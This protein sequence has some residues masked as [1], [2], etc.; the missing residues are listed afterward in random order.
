LKIRQAVVFIGFVSFSL[1]GFASSGGMFNE[2]TPEQSYQ[3]AQS[4][5][6]P[7]T[8]SSDVSEMAKVKSIIKRSKEEVGSHRNAMLKKQSLT[9]SQSPKPHVAKALKSQLSLLSQA[10]LLY[11]QQ[12]NQKIES[13]TEE[14]QALRAKMNKLT[15]AL[16]LINQQF[17]QLKPKSQVTGSMS[18]ATPKVDRKEGFSSDWLQNFRS[19]FYGVTEYLAFSIMALLLILMVILLKRNKPQVSAPT[20]EAVAVNQDDDVDTRDEYDFMSSRE[21]IPA[22]LDLAR[23]YVEMGDKDAAQSVLQEVLRD[24]DADQQDAAVN[25]LN[26]IRF[27]T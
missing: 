26:E 16:L 11:Q 8:A 18:F 15:E 27:K 10:E 2:A 17:S 1:L 12:T 25:L 5:E 21:A 24:G 9:P 14:N 20:A 3:S 23:T 22:K 19:R 13:L 7:P 6:Q 4:P